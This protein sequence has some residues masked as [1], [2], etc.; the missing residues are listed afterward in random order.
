MNHL[1]RLAFYLI[2]VLLISHL[3][4]DLFL[5]PKVIPVTF[6]KIVKVSKID[7][8]L[9]EFK[10]DSTIKSLENKY[11][12]VVIDLQ[13]EHYQNYLR[14]KAEWN[15]KPGKTVVITKPV[16][17]FPYK[18]YVSEYEDKF[19]RIEVGVLAKEQPKAVRIQ[20]YPKPVTFKDTVYVSANQSRLGKIKDWTI[21][22][23]AIIGT[24]KIAEMIR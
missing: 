5:E 8:T 11:G 19:S 12:S 23:L 6:T 18:D 14:L 22:G 17:E 13:K 16:I 7:T 9:T 20:N 1:P 2:A 21:K 3:I 4:G 10:I 24:V 15:N